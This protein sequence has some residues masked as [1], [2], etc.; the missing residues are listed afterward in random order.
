MI[1]ALL[2]AVVPS[3]PPPVVEACAP[4]RLGAMTAAPPARMPDMVTELDRRMATV[5]REERALPPPARERWG[6]WPLVVDGVIVAMV[7]I[8]VALGGRRRRWI[9]LVGALAVIGCQ[10]G[11]LVAEARSDTARFA[12]L[13]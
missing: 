10:V 7:A 11:F 6:R 1:V 3:L 4:A 5:L 12:L 2:L 9:A 8:A 13:G